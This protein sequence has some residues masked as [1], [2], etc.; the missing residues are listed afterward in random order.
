METD[1]NAY[2]RG[3][4]ADIVANPHDD[5]PRLAYSDLLE[6]S[7]RI[8]EAEMI[9]HQLHFP[10]D[11]FD[12]SV[13]LE[14]PNGSVKVVDVVVRRG[15]PEVVRARYADLFG[16]GGWAEELFSRYPILEVRLGHRGIHPPQGGWVSE[17][18]PVNVGGEVRWFPDLRDMDP[19]QRRPA[20]SRGELYGLMD[21]EE[22][23]LGPVRYRRYTDT[24]TLTDRQL[25]ALDLCN[26]AVRLGRNMAGLDRPV[27][28]PDVWQLSG[29]KG[30]KPVD[31]SKHARPRGRAA[32]SAA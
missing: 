25:A 14:R 8:G 28:L 17:F 31:Q 11:Q 6:E 21:G 29:P 2:E 4:F 9:R 27:R 5:L 30:R 23:N 15:F 13:T 18:N 26:A 10:K 16:P 3:V 24:P 22:V 7:G 1:F 32:G 19:Y 12:H 20:V